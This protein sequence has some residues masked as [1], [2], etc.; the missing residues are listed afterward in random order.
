MKITEIIDLLNKYKHVT[1]LTPN[2][3]ETKLLYDRFKLHV[4][5]ATIVSKDTIKIDDSYITFI[6]PDCLNSIN[7]F[8]KVIVEFSDQLYPVLKRMQI[9]DDVVLVQEIY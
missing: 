9:C 6:T 3:Y 2:S 7:P 5:D 1:I 8:S 4:K